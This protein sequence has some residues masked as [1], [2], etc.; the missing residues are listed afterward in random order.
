MPTLNAYERSQ[1]VSQPADVQNQIEGSKA[2]CVALAA[3]AVVGS[4]F[5]PT[6]LLFFGMSCTFAVALLGVPA[7]CCMSIVK[8]CLRS[9]A[10]PSP[11]TYGATAGSG[12]TPPSGTYRQAVYDDPQSHVPAR[13]SDNGQVDGASLF[14][15]ALRAVGHRR[16]EVSGWSPDRQHASVLAGPPPSGVVSDWSLGLQDTSAYAPPPPLSTMSNVPVGRHSAATEGWAAAPGFARGAP[17]TDHVAVG[18]KR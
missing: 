9:V 3:I 4:L 6:G 17:A 11:H 2:L 8:S 16:A 5:M 18:R 10:T 12:A 15:S 7:C 13:R 1:G 14:V